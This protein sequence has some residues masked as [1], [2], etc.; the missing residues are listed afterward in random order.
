MTQVKIVTSP[1]YSYCHAANSLFDQHAISYQEIDLIN[2][3]VQAQ[4]LL[5]ASGQRTVPHSLLTKNPLEV[6]PN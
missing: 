6:L 4:Q 3:S 2:D 1:S 5:I